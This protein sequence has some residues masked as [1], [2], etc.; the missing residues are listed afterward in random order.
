MGIAQQHPWMGSCCSGYLVEESQEIYFSTGGSLCAVSVHGDLI[1]S[2]YS[3]GAIVIWK[4][5]VDGA[6]SYRE[7]DTTDDTQRQ[8]PLVASTAIHKTLCTAGFDNGII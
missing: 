2:G 5:S 8:K 3:S 6:S 7:L 1:C 4:G